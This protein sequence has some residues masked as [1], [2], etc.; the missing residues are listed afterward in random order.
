VPESVRDVDD[1]VQVGERDEPAT[2]DIRPETTVRIG[3]DVLQQFVSILVGSE[4]RSGVARTLQAYWAPGRSEFTRLINAALIL[5]A[6][7]ELNV[8]TF[9][10]R[11]I[12]SAGAPM[13]SAIAGGLAALR[14][15]R[16]GGATLKAE[17]L[18]NEVGAPNAAY[19][20]LLNRLQRGE[21]LAGFGHRLYPSG[22]PR[23]AT[24]LALLREATPDSESVELASAITDAA[25]ELQGEHP[26]LDFGLVM[27]CHALGL[28]KG[29]ALALMALGRTVGWIAHA[30]EEYDR[31][32]LIRPRAR[33]AGRPPG[34]DL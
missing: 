5:C 34:S 3:M 15:F 31:R 17:A 10:V 33:Y 24:L 8:S 13:H 7:H 6:D 27:L 9:T 29:S 25:F 14:G 21:R 28:P 30:G 11:C 22:D 16:H 1:R 4:G 26:N 18:V 23:G 12:A 2:Y 32:Q 20:S 19:E